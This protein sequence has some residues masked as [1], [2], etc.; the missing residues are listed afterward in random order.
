M[1]LKCGGADVSPNKKDG[2]ECQRF[3]GRTV[4]ATTNAAACTANIADPLNR[5]LNVQRASIGAANNSN[6]LFVSCTFEGLLVFVGESCSN[7]AAQFSA[8]VDLFL[9]HE[10]LM[11]NTTTATTTITSTA[12]SSPT[13]SPTTTALSSALGEFKCH[14]HQ[15]V[16]YL[17][18]DEEH[19]Y[20]CKRTAQALAGLIHTCAHPNTTNMAVQSQPAQARRFTEAFDDASDNFGPDSQL[21]VDTLANFTA[22]VQLEPES[23]GT[24]QSILCGSSGGRGLRWQVAYHPAGGDCQAGSRAINSML[25]MLRHPYDEQGKT[26]CGP[27]GLL[28]DSGGSCES[29]AQKLNTIMAQGAPYSMAPSRPSSCV[30]QIYDMPSRPL[31]PPSKPSQ[32][33]A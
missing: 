30:P 9:G 33:S 2:V 14:T 7:T 27:S 29:T 6:E 31:L 32:P 17:W 4:L 16:D 10:D 15:G 22:A 26:S 20:K 5:M 11:C 18:I 21:F 25:Q 19:D 1:R 8:A 23:G 24:P 12:T 13:S 3:A 28:T